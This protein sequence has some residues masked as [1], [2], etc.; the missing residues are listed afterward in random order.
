MLGGKPC[1]GSDRAASFMVS[2]DHKEAKFDD[3]VCAMVPEP[4]LAFNG[5]EGLLLNI[6][7]FLRHLCSFCMRVCAV[8]KELL[9]NHVA[10][11]LVPQREVSRCKYELLTAGRA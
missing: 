2:H 5:Q 1:L 8:P 6:L 4:Q 11:L 9:V 7:S 3:H 10:D